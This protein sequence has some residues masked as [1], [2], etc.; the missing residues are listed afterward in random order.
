MPRLRGPCRGWSPGRP[1]AGDAGQLTVPPAAT[2]VTGNASDAR[3]GWEPAVTWGDRH[4][5]LPASFSNGGTVWM[6]Q[7]TPAGEFH[8]MAHGLTRA[9][10]PGGESKILCHETACCA[11]LCL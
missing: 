1:T 8:A 3:R 4:R 10:S 2:D 7:L 11:T 5:G 6:V 9:G